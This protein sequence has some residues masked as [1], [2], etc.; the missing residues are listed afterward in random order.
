MK[1]IDTMLKEYVRRLNDDDLRYLFSRYSQLL[2]GDRA[3][4]INFLSQ[5]KDVDRW[6]S[7]ASSSF[8]LFNMVDE[9]GELVTE[10]YNAKFEDRK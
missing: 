7:S 10:A 9:L 6:L 2:C 5:A 4:A 3:D 8:E 1:N